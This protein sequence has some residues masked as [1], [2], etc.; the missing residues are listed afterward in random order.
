MIGLMRTV[1]RRGFRIRGRKNGIEARSGAGLVAESLTFIAE[2][3]PMR[4]AL[5]GRGRPASGLETAATGALLGK[6]RGCGDPGQAEFR[7][8]GLFRT[9][10]RWFSDA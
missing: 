3:T 7:Q 5:E 1:S 9:M 4:V 6:V 2:G 10:R 8:A